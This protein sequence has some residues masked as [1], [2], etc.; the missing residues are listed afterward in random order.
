MDQYYFRVAFAASG[1]VLAIP[2][3]AQGDGSVSYTEGFGFD[4]E[5]NPASDPAAKRIPRDQT[6]ELYRAITDGLGQY[7]RFGFPEWITAANNGGTAYSYAKGAFVRYPD[8]K[9][10]GSLVNGNTVTP[11]SDPTK[12]REA[13]PFSMDALVAVAGDYATPMSNVLLATPGRL[14]TALREGKLSY[15]AAARAGTA[16]TVTLPGAAFAQGVGAVVEFTVPDASPAGPLT[17]KLGAL[18]ALPLV[19]AVEDNL[20]AG[21]LQPNRVYRA[22]SNGSKWLVI[23]PLPS[24]LSPS[25]A[26]P[27][28]LAETT[29]DA[30]LVTDLNTALTNGWYRAAAAVTNGPSALAAGAIF[31]SVEASDASNVVQKARAVS[32]L[33]EA[34]TKA[35]ERTRIAGTW[36]PWFRVLQTATEIQQSALP[37]GVVSHTAGSVAPNGWLIRNGAAVSRTTYAALF[38]VVGTMWGVGDGTTTFNLPNAIAY[39]DRGGTPDGVSVNDTVGGH[40]HAV[41]PP[42]CASEGGQGKTVTG[43][44]GIESLTSYNTENNNPSGET[45]PK[46]QK[47]LPI[48]KY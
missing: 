47:Y 35:Y 43:S 26:L 30:P 38:A 11:G 32:G 41:N 34:D 9:L 33:S 7:Q 17:L 10:Y 37:P 23:N 19:S 24:Q 48:I 36:G 20:A 27:D 6:N 18:A 1:D 31:V 44:A 2:Q 21:D 28:R 4:Y 45:A 29:G 39:F 40:I 14:A 5:R 42:A 46:H 12:W 15:A 3:A 8:G 16:Y 22:T 25:F 13:E